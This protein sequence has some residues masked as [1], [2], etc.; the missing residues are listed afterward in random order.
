[1][2]ER[3]RERERENGEK[4][5]PSSRREH[6][7]ALQSARDD[8]STGFLV[9]MASRSTTVDGWVLRGRKGSGPEQEPRRTV[10]VTH[11]FFF[12]FFWVNFVM[13]PKWR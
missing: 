12:F 13:E 2:R 3:E 4:W 1:M 11:C 9:P 10:T 7:E 5:G 8:R 6:G